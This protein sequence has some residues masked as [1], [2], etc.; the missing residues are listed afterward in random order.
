[1]LL[2]QTKANF[3]PIFGLYILFLFNGEIITTAQAGKIT[4]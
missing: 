2:R 4:I 3:S 1:M